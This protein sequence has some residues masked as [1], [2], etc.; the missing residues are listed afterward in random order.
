MATEHESLE[1]AKDRTMAGSSAPHQPPREPEKTPSNDTHVNAVHI[2]ASDPKREPL[3]FDDE[4]NG[5]EPVDNLS[6][7]VGII[8]AV[9]VGLLLWALIL[10]IIV[11]LK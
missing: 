7:P 1:I 3:S 6:A 2:F 11:W 8:T 4:E 9:I 10:L 5:N